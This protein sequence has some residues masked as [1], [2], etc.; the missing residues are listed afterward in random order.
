MGNTV[1]YS[2]AKNDDKPRA[3]WVEGINHGVVCS[4]IRIHHW[5]I[6]QQKMFTKQTE[7][8]WRQG[9]HLHQP[10]STTN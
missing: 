3:V 7:D 2:Y 4:R 10:T 1:Q 9:P 5:N 6:R 8:I